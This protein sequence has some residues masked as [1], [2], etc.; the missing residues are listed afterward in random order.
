MSYVVENK[1][2]LLMIM[3]L[4]YSGCEKKEGTNVRKVK[5]QSQF[6]SQP[7][8]CRDASINIFYEYTSTRP[9]SIAFCEIF[10]ASSSS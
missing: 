7:Y 4:I 6:Q 3:N 9:E 5:V 8:C 1:K 10:I 2:I